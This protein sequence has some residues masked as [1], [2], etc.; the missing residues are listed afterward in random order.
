MALWPGH[1]PPLLALV[2]YADCMQ[3]ALSLTSVFEMR[4]FTQSKPGRQRCERRTTRSCRA[5]PAVSRHV[6]EPRDEMES[7]GPPSTAS[8]RHVN[9][10]GN[11]LFHSVKNHYRVLG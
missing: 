3:G 1:C 10:S 4:A 11:T 9:V 2:Q 8:T 6:D 5:S 7:R